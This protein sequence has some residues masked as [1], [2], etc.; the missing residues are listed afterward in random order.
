MRIALLAAITGLVL[1]AVA[2]P[3]HAD[4]SVERRL[5]ERGLTFEKDEDGDYRVVYEYEKER[6][7]QLVIV[8]G[9]T[10]SIRGFVIREV[11]SAAG[12][13][14][15]DPID[16]ARALKLL[17]ESNENK[18]GSWEIAGKTL[19]YVIK[20]PDDASAAQL[21]AAIDIVATVAD[22]MEIELSGKK[23]AF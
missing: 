22:D 7:S 18:L 13:V 3:A 15:E 21:E 4:A 2:A 11:Y 17:A 1:A 20:L 6:R 5:E 9:T 8:R 14:G 12:R 16:G 19:M 23:D 10:E